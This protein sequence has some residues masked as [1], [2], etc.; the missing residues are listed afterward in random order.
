MWTRTLSRLFLNFLFSVLWGTVNFN[1]KKKKQSESLRQL[2]GLILIYLNIVEYRV[3]Q[4]DQ[5]QSRFKF[6][7]PISSPNSKINVHHFIALFGQKIIKYVVNFSSVNNLIIFTTKRILSYIGFN[8]NTINC[9][10]QLNVLDFFS[11]KN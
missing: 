1:P 4:S 10:W 9:L 7:T 5:V 2:S 11:M 8:L 3:V 6:Q